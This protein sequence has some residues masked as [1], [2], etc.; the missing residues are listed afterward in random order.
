MQ[1]KQHS[2]YFYIRFNVPLTSTSEQKLVNV[3]LLKPKAAMIIYH[4]L[5]VDYAQS[6]LI[7]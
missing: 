3:D 1:R 7:V 4:N 2:Q 6:L 5:I